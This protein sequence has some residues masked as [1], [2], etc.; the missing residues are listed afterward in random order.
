MTVRQID[1]ATP[2]SAYLDDEL[3][4]GTQVV[5]GTDYSGQATVSQL[6]DQTSGLADYFEGRPKGGASLVDDLFEGRDQVLSIEDIIASIRR[7]PPEFAP[8]AKRGKAHYSDT[9]YALLGAIIEATTGKTVAGPGPTRG[10]TR[11]CQDR[12]TA[13]PARLALGR[14]RPPSKTAS[15][16]GF[17]LTCASLPSSN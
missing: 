3:L 14:P 12:T 9:N 16:I 7:I 13:K 17:T 4:E 6:L 11:R 1:L 15:Q 5:D 10:P 2:V 8:G